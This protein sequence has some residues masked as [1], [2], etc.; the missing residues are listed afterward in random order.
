MGSED[1]CQ[2]SEDPGNQ[3]SCLLCQGWPEGICWA[4]RNLGE[5]INSLFP[6][7]P[8]DLSDL[9]KESQPGSPKRVFRPRMESLG[10]QGTMMLTV[11]LLKTLKHLKG[12]NRILSMASWMWI[13]WQLLLCHS[14]FACFPL[15]S[16]RTGWNILLPPPVSHPVTH[17]L[18]APAFDTPEGSQRQAGH[19]L[20]NRLRR[21]KW[22]GSCTL[23]KLL[24]LGAWLLIT[25]LIQK[26][27][28]G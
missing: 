10:L 14:Q 19:H 4:Q 5:E 3:E 2:Q 15:G 8:L 25:N 24:N 26:A 6:P 12:T 18:L 9:P 23:G 11:N 13:K 28:G 22:E 20:C 7:P 1:P 16:S 21:A 17:V 27:L